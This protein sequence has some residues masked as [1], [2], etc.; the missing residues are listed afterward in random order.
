VNRVRK[1]IIEEIIEPNIAEQATGCK[2]A[3]DYRAY[4]EKHGY[5]HCLVWDW[6]SS[7][8]DWN[9]LVS[10]DG[11]EWVWMFQENNYPRRGFTWTIQDEDGD[12]FYADNKE[13]L[14]EIV[15]DKIDEMG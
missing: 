13:D 3:G 6:T 8:G 15:R 4:A 2:G 11:K 7:A 5:P 10:K 1:R 12:R 9:F 14:F